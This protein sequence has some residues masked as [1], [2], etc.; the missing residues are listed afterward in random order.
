MHT[1]RHE[2]LLGV[3]ALLRSAVVVLLVTVNSLSAEPSW[4]EVAKA[5]QLEPTDINTLASNKVLITQETYKQVFTPYIGSF[6]PVFITSDSVLNGFH[7][8][9]EE[10]VLRMEKAQRSKLL[11]MLRYLWANLTTTNMEIRGDAKLISAAKQR[12]QIIIGTAVRLLNDE[13]AKLNAETAKLVAAEVEKITAATVVEKPTWLGPPD[14]GFAALDYSRYRPRGFYTKSPTL[15]QYFRATSWLQSIPF[16]VSRDEELAAVALLRQFLHGGEGGQA[17][18]HARRAYLQTLTAMVGVSDDRHLGGL[19]GRS[20]HPFTL[21]QETLTDFR[22]ELKTDAESDRETGLIND[23]LATSDNEQ[24]LRI[25]P[26]FRTPDA[27][28]FQRTTGPRLAR[29]FPDGLEICVALGSARA[30]SL[31]PATGRLALLKE[32]EGCRPLFR[33]ASLY[34]EYLHAVAALL[35]P[36]PADAPA[37][38]AHESWQTKSCQTA[39]AGWSQLRHTWALQAKQT[40]HYLCMSQQEPGY[41]EPNPEFFAR[42]AA[43]CERTQALLE[44]AGAFETPT[45]EIAATLRKGADLLRRKEVTEK[46][47]NG[48]FELLREDPSF[49][50]ALFFLIGPAE[51]ILSPDK[52]PKVVGAFWAAE[53]DRLLNIA[54]AL[55]KGQPADSKVLEAMRQIA[56]DVKPL[57]Q[58]LSRLC[59]RLEALAHK[60]LRQVPFSQEEKRFI[61]QYGEELAGVMLYGGNSFVK[62]RDDAP[63]IVDVFANPQAGRYL[64]VGIG[65]PRALYVLYPTKNS[66]V[67]CRGAVLPYYEF[68]HPQRLTDAEWKTL[69]DGKDKPAQPGWIQPLLGTTKQAKPTE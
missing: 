55:E 10:S 23:L 34:Q 44:D 29:Q 28:M 3:A 8:L 4:Q 61:G 58:R 35:E 25:L 63:R 54:A 59:R 38:L 15:E 60:Q 65:R 53:A 7:V 16:R 40:V 11:G 41:I 57:W 67:L 62:P 43:L 64:E 39:L 17:E 5:I 69:L 2:S 9:F 12:N 48:L 33:P 19:S 42:L 49:G 52:D 24:N 21:D 47:I 18:A 1:N 26:S 56:M 22:K 51:V 30:A 66:E 36:P 45:E 13:P 32:I 6:L 20:M 14:E 46:G 37:F 31:L 50:E 27:V 68:A